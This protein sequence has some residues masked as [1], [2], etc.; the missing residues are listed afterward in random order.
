MF[1]PVHCVWL[2]V[3]LCVCGTSNFER[4]YLRR[5]YRFAIC[6]TI[7]FVHFTCV[8]GCD[9]CEMRKRNVVQMVACSKKGGS[10]VCNLSVVVIVK[11]GVL[12]MFLSPF[13]MFLCIFVC[14]SFYHFNDLYI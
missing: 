5:Y 9:S 4:F 3:S 14:L 7:R 6:F 1:S 10:Q 11:R 8:F 2:L 12:F 13:G